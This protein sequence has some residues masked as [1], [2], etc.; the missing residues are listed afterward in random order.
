M[1]PFCNL[2]MDNSR[3][4]VRMAVVCGVVCDYLLTINM[5]FSVYVGS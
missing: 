1:V 3:M 2:Y 5:I 4:S